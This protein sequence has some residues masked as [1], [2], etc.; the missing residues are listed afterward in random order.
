[1]LAEYRKRRDFVIE[2]L[3]Q[4]PGVKIG[5]P[6]GAFYAYPDISCAFAKGRHA[7][8]M[9]FAEQLL[10]KAHVAVVPGE[11]FGTDKHIR[12]SYATS[13]EELKRGLDR[14]T[15]SS[16]KHER[17]AARTEVCRAGMGNNATCRRCFPDQ[18]K[19]IGEVWFDAGTEF[20]LL[21]KFI[22]TSDEAIRAGS[23]R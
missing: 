4:I 11:A 16:S 5:V 3:R 13:M 23:S 12:L 15:N 18:H 6:K 10:A 7:H 22:F 1:M 21:I 20:P 9:Q 8:P 17:S 14:F 2:R 19:K